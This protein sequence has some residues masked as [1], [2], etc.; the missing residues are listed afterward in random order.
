VVHS[1]EDAVRRYS[2]Q[3]GFGPWYIYTYR[4][5]TGFVHGEQQ[6]FSVRIALTKVDDY[7]QWE[8]LEP[9]DD[10]SIYAEFL[11][12]HGEG[13]QHVGFEVA[14]VPSTFDYVGALLRSDNPGLHGGMQRYA[15]LDTVKDL[16]VLAEVMDYTDDW[17][18]S[19]YDGTYPPQGGEAVDPE[20]P[21]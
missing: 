10:T 18:R 12:R 7:F 17:V 3:F 2:D 14:D 19:G 16:G 1:V 8:L 20:L 4:N 21:Y 6:T 11:R 5:A 13:V 15:M 9:L